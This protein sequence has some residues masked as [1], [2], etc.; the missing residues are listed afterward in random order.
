M[1]TRQQAHIDSPITHPPIGG[2]NLEEHPHRCSVCDP[3]HYTRMKKS[4]QMLVWLRKMVL[5]LHV[6]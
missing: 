1:C 4:Q 3:E 2:Q 5:L 6:F